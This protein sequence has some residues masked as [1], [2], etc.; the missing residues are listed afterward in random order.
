MTVPHAKKD[1]VEHA[2]IT[3]VQEKFSV[4]CE[5]QTSDLAFAVEIKTDRFGSTAHPA[6]GS[7]QD[8]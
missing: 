5:S 1:I 6:K 4:W 3:G 8:W 2:R 7:G